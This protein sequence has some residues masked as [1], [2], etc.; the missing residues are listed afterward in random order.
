MQPGVRSIAHLHTGPISWRLMMTKNPIL[1][2]LRRTRE[3]LLAESGGT[4]AALVERLQ[5]EEKASGRTIRKTRRTDHRTGPA[6]S[7]VPEAKLLSPSADRGQHKSGG[8]R[9]RA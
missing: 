8:S 3:R 1:D 4:L 5:A 6:K 7:G 2:D 9:D